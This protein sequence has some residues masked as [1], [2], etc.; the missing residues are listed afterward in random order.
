[1]VTGSLSH[2]MPNRILDSSEARVKFLSAMNATMAVDS[3]ITV[4]AG[5]L[6]VSGC[7]SA[8]VRKSASGVEFRVELDGGA[9]L[10]S[11]Q[12][13]LAEQ[14]PARVGEHCVVGTAFWPQARFE[15]LHPALR[16]PVF[17]GSADP[18]ETQML[19]Y[20]ARLVSPNGVVEPDHY[21]KRFVE[22]G[23]GRTFLLDFLYLEGL[24]QIHD[25]SATGIGITPYAADGF[26]LNGPDIDGYCSLLKA[27][28]RRE[29]AERLCQAGC[30]VPVT[31]AIIRLD[32]VEKLWPDGR[33]SAAAIIV[34]GSRTVLR[35]QQCD[36]LHGYFHS[37]HHSRLAREYFASR[38]DIQ[39]MPAALQAQVLDECARHFDLRPLVFTDRYRSLPAADPFRAARE[40]RLRE[41]HEH[42]PMMIR[43]ARL[44][45]AQ[46]RGLSPDADEISSE[47]YVSWFAESIGKQMAI[48]RRE[49]F[50]FD[51]RVGRN[52]SIANALHESQVSLLAEFHDLDTGVFTESPHCEGIILTHDQFENLRRH[53]SKWHGRELIEAMAMIR[54]MALIVKPGDTASAA[55]AVD[56]GVKAY[57]E[58]IRERLEASLI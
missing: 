54:S 12:H 36:P 37:P 2:S 40:I 52:A 21:S 18:P 32:G 20:L 23:I 14:C 17:R 34:R 25:F 57:T 11:L 53:Y 15:Y 4:G 26:V 22:P 46:E 44:R 45:L 41:I 29:I 43:L 50:L 27:E 3:S 58:N 24:P 5:D 8:V 33:T 38:P 39:S 13:P 51:Y 48:M 10:D 47:D 42:A 56:R 49:R 28:H 35:V 19:R 30:R 7:I 16:G 9:S 55:A 1:M 31:G 6:G